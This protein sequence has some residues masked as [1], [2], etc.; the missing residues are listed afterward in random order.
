M[1]ELPVR[2]S[3]TAGCKMSSNVLSTGDRSASWLLNWT[4]GD[5][6]PRPALQ[7]SMDSVPIFL[8]SNIVSA[9]LFVAVPVIGQTTRPAGDSH[10]HA[11]ASKEPADGER[12]LE[13]V[14]RLTE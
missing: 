10:H 3:T 9:I 6:S 12:V 7:A 14:R 5:R 8:I 4:K 13:P 1:L 11:E 2:R